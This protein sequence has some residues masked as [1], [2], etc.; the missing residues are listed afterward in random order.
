MRWGRVLSRG[1]I[2]FGLVF[3]FFSR[4]VEPILRLESKQEKQKA[5]NVSA[6]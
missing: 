6:R 3:F 2:L 1:V 4:K 5:I